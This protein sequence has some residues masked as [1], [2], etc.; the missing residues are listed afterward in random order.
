MAFNVTRGWVYA[1]ADEL[2]AIRLGDGPRPRLR[3]DPPVVTQRLQQ[4]R[5]RVSASPPSTSVGAGVSLL[6]IGPRAA[7]AYPRSEVGA[8][9]WRS[10]RLARSS[11]ASAR[12]AASSRCAS[13]P[14]GAGTS[15]R[16]AAPR[17]AGRGRGPRPS[18][19]TSWPTSSAGCG[20]PA[21]LHAAEAPAAPDL[22]RVRLGVARGAP[23][24]AR[25]HTLAD[26]TWQLCNHL[27]PF[28]HRHHLPQITVAEV[29][30]YRAL[31][32]REQVL[33]AESINKTITRARADPRRGRG[34][35]PDPAQPG[36]RQHPQPQAEGETQAADLPR[37]GRADRRDD[38]RG[39]R[40]RRQA[41]GAHRRAPRADRDAR[42][43]RPAHRRG[44][45]AALAGRRP[46][47][48]QDLGRRRQDRGRHPARRHPARRCATSCSAT[49]TPT[50]APR[51]TRWCS[52][53]RRA[54]AATRTT[55]ASA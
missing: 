49:A 10:R 6:P 45:G 22:P 2:G 35:R 17:T 21:S 46:R 29:D 23:R 28:F 11:S 15:S 18:C 13:A 50:P 47:Q 27:L 38:R 25:S 51:R 3:F 39:H 8:S 34:A 53:R 19:A 5:G 40:A 32:V 44:D 37:V 20:R 54:A 16:S 52:R 30:R 4:R 55:P 14:T 43:R 26:Y 12:A 31:K 1:H 48:R 7:E 24:R 41:A 42:L 9:R 36:P 33:S